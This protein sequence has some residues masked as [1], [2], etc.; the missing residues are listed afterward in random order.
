MARCLVSGIFTDPQGNAVSGA[1]VRV[2]LDS[3]VFDASGNLLMPKEVTTT[4]AT[5]GSWSI[6]LIQS[7]SCVLTLD[8]TPTTNSP[9]VKYKFSLIT[10]AATTATFA[11][12]W[13]EN[14]AFAGYTTSSPLTFAA[15]SGTLLPTQLP[16]TGL[17]TSINA[18]STAAQVI[19]GATIP[20]LSAST[21]AGT[22]TIT[23]QVA[24]T[25]ENGYLASTDWNTFNNKQA[26]LGSIVTPGTNPKVT[27]NS[28]GLVTAGTTLSSGDIPN[29]AANT[30]G[31]SGSC[32][33][34]SA[35]VT[36]NANLTG[37]ITSSGNAT[38][39]A[40]QTGTGSTFVMQASPT[41]TTPVIGAATGTS[42]SV[43]GQVTSTVTTGTAPFVVSST[44]Q[45]ANLNAATAGSA[46]SATTST[47]ATNI[48]GGAG[49]SI[50]YQSA[51]N[52]T[53]L[54]ANGSA[55]TFLKSQGTT[56]AP[57][58]AN[59]TISL[60]APTVQKFTSGTGTY[61]TPT[62]PAP[63][64][65]KVRLIGGGGGG[66]GGG[67]S[68]TMGAGG[69][70]GNS[71]FGTSLLTANGGGGAPVN[72]PSGTGGSVTVTAGPIQL[73]ALTGGSGGGGAFDNSAQ[74]APCG[75]SGAASYFGGGGGGGNAQGPAAG[76]AA[77]TNSGAG[78]G[79]GGTGNGLAG[80]GGSGGGA[81]GF[82]EA[83]ISSP[84]ATYSY[85]VGAAGSAGTAG[86]TGAAG[87]AGGSG[88]IIVEE[89][90]Q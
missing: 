20:G 88:V 78:G 38:S 83:L 39:V 90:Y 65:I 76:L 16:A 21:A 61:T 70:G 53:A 37:P 52:T 11:A 19:T 33:G 22:T 89:F 47:T 69:S 9:V 58:W 49:G 13:V 34:N 15:I 60:T 23:Q 66:S 27:Y 29:N 68:S 72:G 82:I 85:A 7:I 32:T 6:S 17:I 81:G 51:A 55:G 64:Y 1:T 12:C 30:S 40:S 74:N 3:P 50:P 75:Q 5:N 31:S 54:L 80:Y 57:V 59:P 42:L 43:S 8:L 84:S 77:I 48:A 10:P 86:T 26:A 4:T 44:T 71:T 41:L 63:I 73:I 79:G 28:Q 36:T 56:L 46:T 67:L 62:R 14:P 25:T 24:N 2:N 35:T 87:G 18:D 45:V